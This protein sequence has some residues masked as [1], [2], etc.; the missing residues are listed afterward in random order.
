MVHSARRAALLVALLVGAGCADD[1][2]PLAAS[3]VDAGAPPDAADLDSGP[4]TPDAGLT[5]DAAAPDAE[6]VDAEPV[7]AGPPGAPIGAPCAARQD[8]QSA[9]HP[10]ADSYPEAC[11]GDEGEIWPGGYCIDYCTLP[12]GPLT[13]PRLP[14]ADCPSDGV[15]LSRVAI[16]GHGPPDPVGICV[17]ACTEDSE[18]RTD[19][20]YFCRHRFWQDGVDLIFDNGYCAP[21]H[22]STRG[23]PVSFP[24]QC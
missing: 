20:G 4:A 17:K 2:G 23:C 18:C 9:G 11:M 15:C 7:D 3:G 19:E 8:C 10:D 22:C 16:P 24:C 12:E 1:T 5:L 21:S 6:P 13:L 14:Q